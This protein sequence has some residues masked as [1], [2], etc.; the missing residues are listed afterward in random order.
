M[1][2][3]LELY[4]SIFL[5]GFCSLTLFLFVFCIIFQS[6]L[7]GMYSSTFYPPLFLPNKIVTFQFST[8]P[9]FIFH[10]ITLLY[11]FTL[12]F[13]QECYLCHHLK[14]NIDCNWSS[15]MFISIST[16]QLT[17]QVY[18]PK[19]SDFTTNFNSCH[20]SKSHCNNTDRIFATNCNSGCESLLRSQLSYS[21]GF[22]EIQPKQQGLKIGCFTVLMDQL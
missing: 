11:S 4:T 20:S 8:A 13:E 12:I 14:F 2:Q 5:H 6:I 21:P 1:S 19:S 3:I 15:N 10:S 17:L 18:Y 22:W 9:I 16:N 7:V